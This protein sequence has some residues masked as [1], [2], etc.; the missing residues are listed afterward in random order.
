ML[1]IELIVNI[2]ETTVDLFQGHTVAFTPFA[3]QLPTAAN[4]F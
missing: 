1:D 3:F 2:K 4:T